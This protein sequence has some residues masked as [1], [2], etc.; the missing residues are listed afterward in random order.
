MGPEGLLYTS[1][2]KT[3][4]FGEDTCKSE[5]MK[6][7]FPASNCVFYRSSAVFRRGV[8]FRKYMAVKRYNLQLP[9][10]LNDAVF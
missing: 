4:G 8:C 6:S 10:L 1:L 2:I 9:L 5:S 7:S 3:E